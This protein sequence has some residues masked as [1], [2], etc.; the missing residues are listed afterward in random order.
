MGSGHKPGGDS[1][2]ATFFRQLEWI[3]KYGVHFHPTEEVSKGVDKS[4]VYDLQYYH[5]S[6]GQSF[7][8]CCSYGGPGSYCMGWQVHEKLFRAIQ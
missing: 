2:H 7:G 1:A 6:L 8:H 3:I 5:D 4:N